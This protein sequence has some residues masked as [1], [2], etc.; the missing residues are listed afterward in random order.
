M[1]SISDYY[2]KQYELVLESRKVLLDYCK[3][4]S[5]PDFLNANSS[6]G[7]GGS[8]RNLLVHI[9]NTYEFWIANNA[10]KKNIDYTKY[11]SVNSVEEAIALFRQVDSRMFEFIEHVEKDQTQQIEYEVNGKKRAVEPFNL[12]SHVITHEFHHKGQILS[13]SRHLGYTPVDTDIIR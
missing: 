8:I 12:F 1:N 9:A 2:K 4:V 13:L 5:A 3:T 10:L 7:R 11:E 6:F